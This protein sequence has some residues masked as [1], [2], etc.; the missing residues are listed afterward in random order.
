MNWDDIRV[1]I[2]VARNGSLSGAAAVL[3][4]DQTTV[5]R[6]LKRF[7]ASTG[8]PLFVLMGGR[9]YLT[10]AGRDLWAEACRIEQ[11]AA[12]LQAVAR[13][14]SGQPRG[15]V[16]LAASR[17]VSRLYLLPNL[18]A[19]KAASPDITLELIVSD[20][21]ADLARLEADLAL[22]LVAPKSGDLVVRRIGSIAFDAYVHKEAG[23][24]TGF[25]GLSGRLK[26]LPEAHV[27]DGAQEN[28]AVFFKTNDAD[29]FVEAVESGTVK[30]FLPEA[31]A[32]LH[33]DLCRVVGSATIKRDIW[34]V[35]RSDMAGSGPV[36]AAKAWIEACFAQHK[37]PRE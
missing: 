35:T 3:G 24:N 33:P 12:G 36:K 2:E 26:A 7:E 13:S 31:V 6:R 4:L 18:N 15:H 34:L 29:L 20:E 30:A 5:S 19:L 25:A 16:R 10:D 8:E 11:A 28:E 22:R 23:P 37:Q 17:I 32:S 9:R 27:I 1:F 21:L 14:R